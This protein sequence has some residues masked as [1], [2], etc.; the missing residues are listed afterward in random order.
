MPGP[1]LAATI[2]SGYASV[3]HSR[4]IAAVYDS[5]FLSYLAWNDEELNY[6]PCQLNYGPC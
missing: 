4:K 6:G 3:N 1:R 2:G 5:E